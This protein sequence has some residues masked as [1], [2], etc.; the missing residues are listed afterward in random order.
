MNNLNS[1][2]ERKFDDLFLNSPY[3]IVCFN[4]FGKIV[5]VNPAFCHI[6]KVPRE[7]IVGKQALTMIRK[8]ISAKYI[9]IMMRRLKNLLLGKLKDPFELE[10][11]NKIIE[12]H[13]PEQT[14]SNFYMTFVRDVTKFRRTEL[15]RED[16]IMELKAAEARYHSIFE[17]VGVAIWEE[18]FTEVKAAI[19]AKK[20]KGIKDFR[21][22]LDKHPKFVEK[23]ISMIKILDINNETIKMYKAQDKADLLSSLR[24]TFTPESLASFKEELI[25]IF[26][27]EREFQIEEV[28][29]DLQGQRIDVLLKITFPAYNT[30]FDRILISMMNITENKKNELVQN[31]LFQISQ[32]SSTRKELKIMISDI[33]EQLRKLF[34]VKNFYLALYNAENDTYSY[35]FYID[36]YDSIEDGSEESL[37][38]S[39]TD[40]VRRTGKEILVDADKLNELIKNESIKVYG[41]DSKIWLGAPLRTKQGTIGVLVLQSYDNVNA[42]SQDDLKLLETIVEK[43]ALVVERKKAEDDLNESE[44]KYRGLFESSV[45]FV[46]TL[47]REGTITDVN[48]AATQMTGFSRSELIGKRFK[49]YTNGTEQIKLLRAFSNVLKTGK[50]LRNLQYDVIIKNG[51]T[52]NLEGSVILLK[53]EGEI[54]GF[55]GNSRDITQ[56]KL[57]EQNIKAQKEHIELINSILRHDISNDLSVITSALNLYNKTSKEDLLTEINKRVQ[58]SSSLIRRMKNLEIFLSRRSHLLPVNLRNIVN[59]VK[60]VFPS[61]Q[62]IVDGNAKVLADSKLFSVFKNIIQNSIRHGKSKVVHIEVTKDEHLCT[63]KIAD[64]GQG[65]PED[66]KKRLFEK[67]YIFG[68]TGHSGLGLYIVKR[69]IDEYGGSVF[70]EDN[71][72]HGTILILRLKLVS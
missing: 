67:G 68:E 33:R 64:D 8:Y 28:T 54:I 62:I 26:N 10:F 36:E 9:P 24:N 58:H 59:D 3:G 32:I 39:L 42:Y 71:K 48:F 69:S 40:Y 20:A 72:P 49:E 38:N 21:D 13:P 4:K 1:N 55:Q 11:N 50:P 22:Y 51:E 47:D 6:T 56:R 16:K 19:D 15:E 57:D 23:A 2:E 41:I 53:K 61:I 30:P 25:A 45:D 70:V 5:N 52:R 17:N 43:I 18:D 7:E 63:I 65:I 34:D 27:G 35:P 66:A 29:Q 37:P 44:E 12:F 14:T 60:G 31:V 46:Y